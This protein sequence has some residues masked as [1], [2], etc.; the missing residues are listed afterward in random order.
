MAHALPP[1][2]ADAQLEFLNQLQRLFA[3]GDFVATYKFSLLIA[4]ADLAVKLG[5]DNGNG[6]ELSLRQ[7]ARRFIQNYWFQA[8]PYSTGK[9]HLTAG[10]L[11]QNLGEQ[12]AAV[13]TAIQDFKQDHG[14]PTFVQASKHPQFEKLVSKV[15]TT[16]SAQPLKYLQ[17][18]GGTT[19]AFLYERRHGVVR[20]LPGV[21]F[22]LRR[23]YPLV[24]HLARSHWVEHIKKNHR[25]RP[26]LGDAGDLENF[27]FETPR[28]TLDAVC[29]KLLKLDG[30]QCFYCRER[31][32]K[33]DV[34][35]FIPFSQY[36]RDIGQNFVL[37]HA[38]CNRSKSNALAA[39]QH[40]QHWLER[41]DKRADDLAAISEET[42]V[43][44][45]VEVMTRVA[46][47]SYANAVA[48]HG[49]AWVQPARFEAITADYLRHFPASGG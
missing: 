17:N 10:V 18:F 48:A 45:D 38:R 21:P 12:Q 13:I 31:L 49:H 24:Q 19:T 6:L 32:S 2:D 22:Y 30:H 35:H 3:E 27:L 8:L 25:N 20:L 5:G 16:V 9:P 44:S 11:H 47:W 46:Q 23:F 14:N 39:E 15:V 29:T 36:P 7:I 43:T 33:A 41:L 4:L 1:P 28:K 42:G 34:D 40:L 37:A 26:I